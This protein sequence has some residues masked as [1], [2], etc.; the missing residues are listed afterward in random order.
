[1]NIDVTQEDRD[2][3]EGFVDE[4]RKTWA[5]GL[6]SDEEVTLAEDLSKHFAAMRLSERAKCTKQLKEAAKQWRL[7][8]STYYEKAL[9]DA[10]DQLE[11]GA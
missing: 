9:V 6:N 5:L 3:A 4:L 1:M 10:A 11:K 7:R 8:G 2:A